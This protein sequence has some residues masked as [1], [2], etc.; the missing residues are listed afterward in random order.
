MFKY[1]PDGNYNDLI[2][3][4]INKAI[5]VAEQSDYLSEGANSNKDMTNFSD[6][7]DCM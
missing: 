2:M 1:C 7:Q 3:R 4:V 5:E 6:F